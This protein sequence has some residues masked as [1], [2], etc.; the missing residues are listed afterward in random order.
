MDLTT[1]AILSVHFYCKREYEA[2]R[3]CPRSARCNVSL[4]K[5]ALFGVDGPEPQDYNIRVSR[6]VTASLERV[7]K[8]K[9]GGAR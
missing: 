9:N 4:L 6:A 7:K 5:V 2:C 8:L 3:R 1:A